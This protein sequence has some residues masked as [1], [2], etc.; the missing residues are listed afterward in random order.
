MALLDTIKEIEERREKTLNRRQ[1]QLARGEEPS[2]MPI[3]RMALRRA[4][5]KMNDVFQENRKKIKEE[6]DRQMRMNQAMQR[7]MAQEQ[8][9]GQAPAPQQQDQMAQQQQPQQAPQGLLGGVNSMMQGNPQ[10]QQMGPAQ[11]PTGPYG[12]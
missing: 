11:T 7:A 1:N 6:R 2:G 8:G 5:S 3:D 4:F 9:Q 12:G 10:Q